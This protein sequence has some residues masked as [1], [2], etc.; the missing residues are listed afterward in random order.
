MPEDQFHLL[1]PSF[2]DG[3]VLAQAIL[4]LQPAS[5]ALFPQPSHF[6]APPSS[7]TPAELGAGPAGFP[8]LNY[9][10]PAVPL[11]GYP[12]IPQNRPLRTDVA[13]PVPVIP[14]VLLSNSPGALCETIL[15]VGTI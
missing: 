11:P 14:K 2:V 6:P 5:Q 13:V 1:P 10:Y 3:L 9:V 12:A 15:W 4:P 8:V 7:R